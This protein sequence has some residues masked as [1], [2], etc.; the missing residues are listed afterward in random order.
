[1]YRPGSSPPATRVQRSRLGPIDSSRG[2]GSRSRSPSPRGRHH[3]SPPSRRSSHRSHRSPSPRRFSRTYSLDQPSYSPRQ[4]SRSPRQRSGSSVE[5]YLR[6]L[7]ENGT[8]SS[9]DNLSNVNRDNSSDGPIF[10]RALSHPW[11][12]ERGFFHEENSSRLFSMGHDKDYYNRDIFGAQLD[13]SIN[14]E[15]LQ[16]QSRENYRGGEQDSKYFQYDRKD[17]LFDESIKSQA[18]LAETEKYR[19]Q[20]PNRSL[21]LMDV[22]EDFHKLERIRRKREE[23]LQRRNIRTDYP[24]PDS[25]N[26]EQS[27]KSRHHYRSEKTPAVPLK[28][29]LKKRSDDSSTQDSGNFSKEKEPPESTLESVNQHGDFLLPHER[30]SQDGSGFSSTVGTVIDSTYTPDKRLDPFPDNIEDE[31]KF[32]YGDDDGDS[33]NSLPSQKLMLSEKK[34]PVTEKVNS[35]PP[36]SL[37]VKPEILE[38]SS[39]E[40]DKIRDLLK[41]IG[42]DIGVAEVGKLAARTEER[43]YGKK[44]TYSPDHHSV[45][46]HKAELWKRQKHSLS[47]FDSFPSAK[48]NNITKLGQN[49][50]TGTCEQSGVPGCLIPSAPPSFLDIPPGPTSASCQNVPYV[51]TFT[52]NRFFPNCASLPVVLPNYDVYQRHMGYATSGW[53]AQQVNSVCPNKPQ[54]ANLAKLK[55]KCTNP[56]LRIINT[57]AITKNPSQAAS[58]MVPRRTRCKKR[59]KRRKCDEKNQTPLMQMIIKEREALECTQISQQN[60]LFYQKIELDRLSEQQVMMLL[61]KGKKEDP[62][63]M[64]LSKLKENIAKEVARLEMSINAIKEKQGELNKVAHIIETNDFENSEKLSSENKDSSENNLQNNPQ[65]EE[66]TFDSVKS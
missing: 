28:S 53:C 55:G 45:A 19:K 8:S 44:T 2:F 58:T 23:D 12:L 37:S 33:N 20:S 42:L 61:K 27:S 25:A 65:S 57:T 9:A 38:Q 17:R 59:A 56:N 40:Y 39:P 24:I 64:E 21:N 18:L 13:R 7:I 26:Q 1:M 14:S 50:P 5:K 29:I 62:L 41:T 30:A 15:L 16:D 22:D 63:L 35:P 60:K 47:P 49:N 4:R 46:N 32:L 6:A 48:A 51:S 3:R 34:E 11:N 43:L 10:S 54:V 31:E 66:R 52:P 36:A